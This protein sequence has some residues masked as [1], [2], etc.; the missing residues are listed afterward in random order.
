[1]DT[2]DLSG[3]GAAL[4]A[5][6]KT[7]AS[8][9]LTKQRSTRHRA[10]ASRDAL[11]DWLYEQDRNLPDATRFLRDPRAHYFGDPF[12]VAEIHPALSFLMTAGL[13]SG[14]KTSSP[15]VGRPQITDNGR[16]CV[17]RYNSDIAEWQ[18][19]TPGQAGPVYTSHIHN[20]PA[21][22]IMAGSAG[23]QQSSTVMI[24]AEGRTRLA[25]TAGRL[26]EALAALDIDEASRTE[27]IDSAERLKRL[28]QEP[29]A[30]TGRARALFGVI[31]TSAA[32]AAGTEAGQA[33]M[34]LIADGMQSIT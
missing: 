3:A 7:E 18:I 4:T 5:T 2:L 30:D 23:G 28:A 20:S 10:A 33:V 17:E 21:A 16:V 14:F 24:S 8:D 15:V 26:I 9:W 22:Q 19:P 32:V 11:L 13:A 6:G 34:H 29:N 27:A 25:S 31:A 1:M 12:D